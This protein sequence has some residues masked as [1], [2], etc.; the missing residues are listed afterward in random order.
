MAFSNK[1]PCTIIKLA[2]ENVLSINKINK[3]VTVTCLL[4]SDD[5]KVVVGIKDNKFNINPNNYWYSEQPDKH[6]LVV[7]DQKGNMALNVRY[8]NPTA[9]KILG[10]FHYS[11]APYASVIV[12]D[13]K[14]VL[15]TGIKIIGAC[16]GMNGTALAF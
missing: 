9:I 3:G 6:T 13:E 1:L 5:G 2:G 10:T 7:Y 14:I 11:K 8:L 16:S 4:R 15:P 12:D